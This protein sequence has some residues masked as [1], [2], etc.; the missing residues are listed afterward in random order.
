MDRRVLVA[1]TLLLLA[2]PLRTALGQNIFSAVTNSPNFYGLVAGMQRADADSVA[3]RQGWT[4]VE[5]DDDRYRLVDN[6]YGPLSIEI[7]HYFE[8]DEPVDLGHAAVIDRFIVS[9]ERFPVARWSDAIEWVASMEETFTLKYG[10]TRG[11]HGAMAFGDSTSL[12]S[13]AAG[14]VGRTI[15]HW[16]RDGISVSVMIWRN[17]EQVWGSIDYALDD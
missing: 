13:R 8:E 7:R 12:R 14:A 6:V 1:S 5:G 4:I 9:S 10:G 16:F 15:A 2:I 11:G 3:V 17:K